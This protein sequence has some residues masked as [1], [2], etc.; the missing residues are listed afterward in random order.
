M[1]QLDDLM[2]VLN[3][4]FVNSITTSPA[5]SKMSFSERMVVVDFSPRPSDPVNITFAGFSSCKPNYFLE[6]TNFRWFAIEYIVSGQWELR[7]KHGKWTIG[8]GAVFAYGPDVHYS[9]RAKSKQNLAKFF[10]DFD[11]FDAKT[12]M[13]RSTLGSGNPVQMVYRRWIH[14]IFDQI[15][16]T[17]LLP[18]DRRKRF[19]RMLLE[20]LIERIREDQKSTGYSSQ[21][22][23][24]YQRCHEYIIKNYLEITSVSQVAKNCGMTP[25][26]LSR[27]FKR[28][29]SE[30]PRQLLSRLKMN[31][32]AELLLRN[33]LP[34]KQIAAQVGYDDPY[35]F[36]R[37]FKRV[38]G[39]APSRIIRGQFKLEEGR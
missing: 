37:V 23:L 17:E 15:I 2:D 24:S 29:D 10:V 30:S 39:V 7:T 11:G 16:E 6:R 12:L 4:L 5:I 20:L 8:P 3:I 35:H 26:N 28:F 31:R 1:D 34:V 19:C 33:R 13:E 38:I 32:A 18:S 21:A 25:V 9:L 27:L 14:D 22:R 36:S